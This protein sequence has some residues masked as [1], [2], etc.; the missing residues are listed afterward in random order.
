MI[1]RAGR[2]AAENSV[3]DEIYEAAFIPERWPNVLTLMAE[4]AGCT[5]SS[6]FLASKANTHFAV[7]PILARTYDDCVRAG[8]LD[9]T[10]NP[11]ARGML[12]KNH[13]GFV[14]DHDVLTQHDI[15]THPMYLE[16][17]RP[18]G[19][20]WGTG[21]FIPVINGDTLVYSVEKLYDKG[22]V[23]RAN[24]AVLDALR[25]HLARAAV[26]AARVS[27]EKIKTALESLGDLGLPAFAVDES[28]RQIA[29]NSLIEELRPCLRYGA[30]ND[31]GLRDGKA[32]LLFRAAIKAIGNDQSSGPRSFV[33]QARE[34][35]LPAV[36]HVLPVRRD[37]RDLFGRSATVVVGNLPHP[38]RHP[39]ADLLNNIFDLTP[40]QSRVTRLLL[41]GKGLQAVAAEL[42]LSRETVK[43]HLDEVFAKT[44]TR[45]QVD[46]LMLL[47]SL[48]V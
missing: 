4:A 15:D 40:A 47:S 6:M 17:L 26:I 23:T 28:C 36:I 21:T 33:V 48:G 29:E 35:A 16:G 41:T 37:A 45:R 24:V 22:P 27:F 44:G 11:R 10:K 30:F 7:S 13:P 34:E 25:P 14:T 46:L 2:A 19:F 43:S 39:H 9:L 42:G 20:G 38:V 5:A 18:T 32:N 31:I 3:V 12:A 1:Q 8:V